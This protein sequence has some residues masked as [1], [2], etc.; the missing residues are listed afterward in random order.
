M[1]EIKTYYNRY[2]ND[3]HIKVNP[4]DYHPEEWTEENFFYHLKFFK[5]FVKGKLLDFG[6]GD[7]QFLHMISKYCESFYGVDISEVAIKKA[8]NKYPDIKFA[9]LNETGVTDF[10]DNFFDTICAMDILEHI[11]DVESTLEELRRILKPRGKLLIATN[12]LTRIKMLLITLHSLDKYFYPT[13]PHIRY[14]TRRN[15]ADILR[16]KGFEVIGY[17]KNRTYFGIIPRG[18]MVVALKVV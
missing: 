13:S 12:E 8:L 2:W 9:V 16:K 10:P 6:C 5:P 15:L 11:L 4:F 18:Q 17:K 14:F 3:R 7:G 1:R